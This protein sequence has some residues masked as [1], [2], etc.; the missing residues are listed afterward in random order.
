M[1]KFPKFL[2]WVLTTDKED[3]KK[4]YKD[5]IT[6]WELLFLELGTEIMLNMSNLL[7]ANP[8]AGAQ[9]IKDDIEST[10]SAVKSTGDLNLIKKLETQLKKLKSIRGF[11]AITSTEGITFTFNNKLYKY[12][13]TFAPVNQIMGL[14]TF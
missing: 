11:G 2:D 13:G 6:D 9:K 7:T 10:I 8:D 1:K 12:T 14:L 4:I 5:N 3:H